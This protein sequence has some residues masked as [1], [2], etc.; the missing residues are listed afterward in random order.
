MTNHFQN[1]TRVAIA[2]AR[3]LARAGTVAIV[4]LLIYSSA[5]AAL[6]ET[7][8]VGAVFVSMIA[9]ATA[10]VISFVGHKYV[11]FRAGGNIRNQIFLY[12]VVHA[13]CLVVTVLITNLIVNTLHWPYGFAILLVDI[14]VPLISF[15]ALRF[16]VFEERAYARIGGLQNSD[17]KPD[18]AEPL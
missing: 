6:A 3:Q 15:L 5:Y 16:V 12:V 8:H 17:Y 9:Y 18:E 7:T 10:M 1:L 11:T 4:S 14:T 2:E 13:V